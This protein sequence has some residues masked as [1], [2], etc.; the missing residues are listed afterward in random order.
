MRK[1]IT[2]K[3]SKDTVEE[4]EKIHGKNAANAAIADTVSSLIAELRKV[5][6]REIVDKGQ[7][8]RSIKLT[9]D[10]RK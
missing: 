9:V 8:F 3:I 2:M 1:T 10:L 4:L 5:L 6:N 7:F